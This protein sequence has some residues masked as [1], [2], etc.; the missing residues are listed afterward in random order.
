MGTFQVELEIGDLQGERW[1]RLSATVGT[2][3][4]FAWAPR[5]LLEELGI[6]PEKRITLRHL[7]GRLIKRDVAQASLRIG[8]KTAVATVV[9]GD[10]R[11]PA[12]VGSTTLQD[13][14]LAADLDRQK[15]VPAAGVGSPQ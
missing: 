10:K 3:A 2:K 11:D 6:Q 14:Q 15:L 7:D 1:E 8:D 4:A 9:F 13:L 5:E 12:L